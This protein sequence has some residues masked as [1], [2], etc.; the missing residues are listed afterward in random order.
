MLL[1][2]NTYRTR[3]FG[4]LVLRVGLGMMFTIHGYPKLMGG[5]AAWTEVGGVMKLVGLD[6][7]PTAWGL[8][9][10]VAEA[11]GGQLLAVGLFFRI[12]C[13]ALLI[14]MIMA[15]IMHI[16]KGDGFAGYSHAVESA[17]VFLGLLFIGPGRYSLDR[18]L[19]PGPR[20]LYQ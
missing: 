3:D 12:T 11:V 2:E 9:A 13:A 5:Q 8:L 6:F 18:L 15:A 4:L 7:A 1:F 20:R 10:A 16:S 19:F 17:F 14:T